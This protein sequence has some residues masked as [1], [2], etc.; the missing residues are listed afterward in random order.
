MRF[1]TEHELLDLS[2]ER[3]DERLAPI[4]DSVET[5]ER[6]RR[7]RLAVT[8]I[9][10]VATVSVLVLTLCSGLRAMAWSR[11][12]GLAGCALV[13]FAWA[14]AREQIARH[15]LRRIVNEASPP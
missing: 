6:F 2:L 3:D 11:I 12:F 14:V 7:I 8:V 4:L 10:A 9:A 1:E 13:A 15:T 5:Y